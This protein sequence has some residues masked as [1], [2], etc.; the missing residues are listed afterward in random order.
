MPGLCQNFVKDYVFAMHPSRRVPNRRIRNVT[1]SSQ[2]ACPLPNIDYTERNRGAPIFFVSSSGNTRDRRER[3]A[4]Y[5]D[6]LSPLVSYVR[7]RCSAWARYEDGSQQL[8]AWDARRRLAFIEVPV[9]PVGGTR[10]RPGVTAQISA[11][12]VQDLSPFP[13]PGQSA[14]ASHRPSRCEGGTAPELRFSTFLSRV[15]SRQLSVYSPFALSC[16]MFSRHHALSPHLREPVPSFFLF[17]FFS[18]PTLCI[19]VA[20][21]MRYHRGEP[22]KPRIIYME[23]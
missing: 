10:R 4:R 15:Y 11:T 23:R 7:T 1:S 6:K 18:S 19:R 3:C 5:G 12:P 8:R 16:T 2:Q 14:L 9:E 21:P 22:Y 13:E 17:F 20:T